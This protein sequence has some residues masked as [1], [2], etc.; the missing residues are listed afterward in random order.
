[1]LEGGPPNGTLYRSDNKGNITSYAVFD[2][3]GMIIKR[4]DVT[5]KPHAGA[6]TPQAID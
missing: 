5:G 1:M 2:D 4:V 3:K 6:P